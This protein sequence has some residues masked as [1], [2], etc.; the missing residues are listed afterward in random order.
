[1]V[2]AQ[3]I[4][5]GI[6]PLTDAGN[7]EA[8]AEEWGVM[9]RYVY[10]WKSFIIYRKG[11]WELDTAG[12]MKQFAIQTMRKLFQ[13]TVNIPDLETR[14]KASNWYLSSES[15]RRV[16]AMLDLVTSEYGISITA[17]DLDN[18]P[19]LF[20]VK[21]GTFNLE[22]GN[23]QEADP[24]DLL[25]QYVN[26]NYKPDAASEEWDQFL[27]DIFNGNTD[28]ID[29]IQ[30]AVGY[31]INGTQLERVF[32]F[33]YGLGKNGKSAFTDALRRVLG[34]YALEAKPELFMEKRYT[35]DGPDEGQ[36]SLKGIRFLT[37][38]EIKRNQ[39]LDVSLIKRMTGS[40]PIWHE[41]KFQRGF[42]FH[43]THTLWL[44]GNHEPQIKDTTNSIYDRFNK[45]PFDVRITPENEIKG[46]G[47]I[48]ASKHGEA[49]LAWCFHG[50]AKWKERGLADA[51]ACILSANN[52]YR[53]RQDILHDFIETCVQVADCN[54]IGQDMY[55]SYTDFC[56]EDDSDPI[57]KKSFN[58]AM[59]ERGFKDK[60]GHGNK[61][62][63]VGVTLV[64]YVA[65]NRKV[66]ATRAHEETFPY[67][68]N[69]SNPEAKNGGKVTQK[70][71]DYPTRDC[72]NC[73]GGWIFNDDSTGYVCENCGD[74]YEE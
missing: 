31:S 14:K 21:N 40:E 60:R 5:S 74:V 44:S 12:R 15:E 45:I 53:A 30:R 35:K 59:R 17:G 46:Y 56:K 11:Y 51:P 62:V 65:E 28:M 6:F 69:Q 47:E 57:G 19:W 49:I 16:H 34:H 70:V 73:G 29:Y 36:A 37:A 7:A 3:E 58:E 67:S 48:L 22:T 38:T 25:T 1:M 63:W 26:L 20:N 32:F 54:V 64:T 8:L 66:S 24:D 43:P 61:P 13:E 71:P 52:E 55:K 50:A 18:K 72:R 68:G 39:S 42:S 10:E 33:C 23:I 2:M 9:F 41:R 4:P 27:R